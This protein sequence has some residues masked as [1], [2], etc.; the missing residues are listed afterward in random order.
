M[1]GWRKPLVFRVCDFLRGLVDTE[2]SPNW[3]SR[4]RRARVCSDSRFAKLQSN[5]ENC[6][7]YAQ[8]EAV[9]DP[10]YAPHRAS[11]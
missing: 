4:G 11:G 8:A 5:H 2:V 6:L 9:Y 7:S 1:A 10:P 3:V